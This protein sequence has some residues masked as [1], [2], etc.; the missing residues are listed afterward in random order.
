M[1]NTVSQEV[2]L[3]ALKLDKTCFSDPQDM[4]EAFARA[5]V[6]PT[7][8]G[9]D[10]TDGTA[11]ANGVDAQVQINTEKVTAETG[12]TFVD[13]NADLDKGTVS[14]TWV[15]SSTPS[16]VVSITYIEKLSEGSYR[17]HFSSATGSVKGWT[18]T[19]TTI[20]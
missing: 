1:T 13:I 6:V 7:Q 10:G 18:V 3:R 9:K 11:G 20:G 14:L 5:L 16:P 19:A 17:V 12:V 2:T 8:A 4:L 15:S